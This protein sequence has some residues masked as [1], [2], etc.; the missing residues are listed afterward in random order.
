MAAS[1]DQK[2]LILLLRGASF[3][4]SDLDVE[5]EVHNIAILY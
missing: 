2:I 1:E 5:A 4:S 3:A